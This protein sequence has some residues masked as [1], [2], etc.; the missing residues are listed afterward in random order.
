[1]ESNNNK[2]TRSLNALENFI[3]TSLDAKIQQSCDI[4]PEAKL[5]SLF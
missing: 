1:M 4:N 3:K 5:L 2:Q